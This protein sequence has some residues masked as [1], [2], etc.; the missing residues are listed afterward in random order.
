M[1][2]SHHAHRLREPH[3]RESWCCAERRERKCKKRKQRK[4]NN[5]EKK[6]T[7][8]RAHALLEAHRSRGLREPT[9]HQRV[10]LVV[11]LV[12]GTL[13]VVVLSGVQIMVVLHVPVH[14]PELYVIHAL[15]PLH[16]RGGGRPSRALPVCH[17]LSFSV[18]LCLACWR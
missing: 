10:R 14:V 17:S 2:P 13:W 8:D 11:L 6:D 15:R 18:F 3:E 5:E 12:R 7:H 9:S 4:V 1:D 16:V